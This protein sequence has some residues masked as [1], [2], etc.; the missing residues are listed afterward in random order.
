MNNN[1]E[2]EREKSQLFVCAKHYFNLAKNL[3]DKIDKKDLELT[4]EKCKEKFIKEISID[5]SKLPNWYLFTIHL[6]SCSVRLET[7]ES[8]LESNTYQRY[9]DLLR[10][11]DDA[12]L[13]DLYRLIKKDIVHMLNRHKIGHKEE[14]LTKPSYKFLKN[15]WENLKLIEIYSSIENA[16]IRIEKGL[17]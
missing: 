11:K 1:G 15:K 14:S 3:K 13:E 10:L 16:L 9:R 7:I 4:V 8:I 6:G 17:T 2:I 5:D 12:N